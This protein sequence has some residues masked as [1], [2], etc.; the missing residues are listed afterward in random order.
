[1]KF[2]VEVEIL[3]KSGISDPQGQTIERALPAIGFDGISGVRVGKFLTFQVAAS[4]SSAVEALVERACKEFLS[5]PV[6]EDFRF[7]VKTTPETES[8]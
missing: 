2:T 7:R 1:M 8:N 6:I 3:P 4:D 5:N